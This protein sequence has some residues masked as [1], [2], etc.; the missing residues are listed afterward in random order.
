MNAHP[1]LWDDSV[2]GNNSDERVILIEKWAADNNIL[3]A[4]DGSYTHISRSSGSQTAPYLTLTHASM[5]DKLSWEK[6]NGL[7]S[8]HSSIVIPYINCIPTV[9]NKQSFK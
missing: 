7:G 8:D 1:L 3:A 9:Y 6:V 4:N 2:A 5:V